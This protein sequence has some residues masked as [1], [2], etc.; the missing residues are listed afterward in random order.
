MSRAEREMQFP[1]QQPPFGVFAVRK[2]RHPMHYVEAEDQGGTAA[3]D[4]DG[5]H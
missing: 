1:E 3:Q 5:F 2:T 4:R